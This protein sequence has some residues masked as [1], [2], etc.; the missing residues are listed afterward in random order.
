MLM[1]AISS[2]GDSCFEV[3]LLTKMGFQNISEAQMPK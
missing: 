1:G 3:K 2:V